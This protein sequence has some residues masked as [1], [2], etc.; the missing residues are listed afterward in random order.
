MKVIV[1][2]LFFLNYLLDPAV[3]VQRILRSPMH[4][5]KTH[6]QYFWVLAFYIWVVKTCMLDPPV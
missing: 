4:L 5:F 1:I 6:D 2:E 3:V